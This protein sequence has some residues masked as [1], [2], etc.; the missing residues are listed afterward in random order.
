MK[1]KAYIA[2]I[3]EIVFCDCPPLLTPSRENPTPGYD[4][5]PWKDGGGD[6]QELDGDEQDGGA[7]AAPFDN[8][9]VQEW[10]F[11]WQ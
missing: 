8:W 10:D 7:K 1:K 6:E 3:T 2:P 11:S 5:D 4:I 9:G